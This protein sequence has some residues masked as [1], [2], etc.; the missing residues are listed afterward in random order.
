MD[1]HS[2]KVRGAL[3][4]VVAGAVAATA[5]F[6]I[7]ALIRDSDDTSSPPLGEP[8]A[9]TST[10][11]ALDDGIA[12]SEEAMT[13]SWLFSVTA[14]KG[15]YASSGDGTGTLTLTDVDEQVTGFT[16][17]PVRDAVRFELA[18]MQ[19]AWSTLFGDIDPNAVLV[20][21]SADGVASSF[22]VEL[23]NPEV[24]GSSISF[25]TVV[26]Q[27]KDHSSQVPGMES[28]AAVDPP[29][30]LS[31]V[32]LF[33]DSVGPGQTWICQG[34]DGHL[35]NPPAPIPYTGNDKA[36]NQFSAECWSKQG[37]PGYIGVS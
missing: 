1:T 10:S 6:G 30:E 27:G 19:S 33:I 29:A 5:L 17:R 28:V 13:P 21:R 25:A 12:L 34:S 14:D 3:L 11:A 24:D 2:P 32:S 15:T 23:S 37:T 9:S 26:I 36:G 4:S 7:T 22:V 8:V 16:D 20:T 18:G 31:S 35:I